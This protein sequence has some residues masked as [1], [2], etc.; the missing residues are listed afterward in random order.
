MTIGVVMILAALGVTAVLGLVLAAA[1]LTKM[2]ERQELAPASSVDEVDS[3]AG[4]KH[5]PALIPWLVVSGVLLVLL[6]AFCGLWFHG[7]ALLGKKKTHLEQQYACQRSVSMLGIVFAE[8]WDSNKKLP[9]PEVVSLAGLA[10]P[11]GNGFRYVGH[12]KVVIGNLRVIVVELEPHPGGVHQA[13]VADERFIRARKTTADFQASGADAQM[14]WRGNA[15][16]FFPMDLTSYQYDSIREQVE[17]GE[18][19]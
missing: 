14:S 7:C 1:V 12:R 2:R 8:D 6:T 16:Y 18:D 11:R 17:S 15:L 10:C 13:L 3:S 4:K 19:E 5:R 9:A